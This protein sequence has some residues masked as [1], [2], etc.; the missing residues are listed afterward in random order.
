[1]AYYGRRGGYRN[2]YRR[3]NPKGLFKILA[4]AVFVASIALAV[5]QTKNVYK[6]SENE[7]KLKSEVTSLQKKLD[8]VKNYVPVSVLDGTS[9][10]AMAYQKLYPEMKVER[11]Q[12]VDEIDT[13]AI[14]L[15]FEGGPSTTTNDILDY[16]K[17][18]G[19]KAT[20]FITGENISGNEAT[21][22]RIVDEGH[23]IGACG[24]STDYKSIYQSVDAFLADFNK[25][26]NAIY[27]ACGVYP[28]IYRF[29]LGS[30]N[31]YNGNIYRE[32]ISE[33]T[34]RGF[35]YFDWSVNSADDRQNKDDWEAIVQDV[36][37]DIKKVDQAIVLMHDAED[38][39]KTAR[40]VKYMLG[41]LSKNGYYFAPLKPTTQAVSF[42]YYEN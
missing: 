30:I 13:R 19:Q 33:M 16:L 4:V 11:P 14:Y 22:K 8:T 18:K 27:E 34:R 31:E 2:S 25:V 10:T 28:A 21:L 36:S 32:T 20:F 42:D 3:R 15:T 38:N 29:P 5:F 24:F 12:T 6:I 9:E 41:Y 35:V 17:D 37:A 1:M 23:T 40:A 26:Y 7:K 39:G